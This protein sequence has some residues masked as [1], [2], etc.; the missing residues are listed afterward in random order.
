M[1][2]RLLW[3]QE[4][5]GSTPRYPTCDEA[6]LVRMTGDPSSADDLA[7]WQ[8]ITIDFAC[9]ALR[10]KGRVLKANRMKHKLHSGVG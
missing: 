7:H 3:E 4:D 6:V 10:P 9:H 1:E 8:S 2:A 5:L